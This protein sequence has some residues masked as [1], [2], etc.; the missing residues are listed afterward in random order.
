MAFSSS[1]LI[2]PVPL[3]LNDLNFFSYS[4]ISLRLNSANSVKTF[5]LTATNFLSTAS[6]LSIASLSVCRRVSTALSSSDADILSAALQLSPRIETRA[7][8]RLITSSHTIHRR[9][10]LGPLPQVK[11]WRD[12]EFLDFQIRD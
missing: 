6:P 11:K 10:S 7:T 12:D 3:V 1:K 2:F 4:L 5:L 8:D 9:N